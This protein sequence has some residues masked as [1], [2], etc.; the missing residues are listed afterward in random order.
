MINI[1]DE[2]IEFFKKNI[3]SCS[4]R[5]LMNYYNKEII[6]YL[7]NSFI[8][9]MFLNYDNDYPDDVKLNINKCMDSKVVRLTNM[10]KYSDIEIKNNMQAIKYAMY[11]VLNGY[12][13]KMAED[14]NRFRINKL[15][16]ND[17]K[18]ISDIKSMIN[19]CSDRKEKYMV[20]FDTKD[21]YIEYESTNINSLFDTDIKY[22]IV[23]KELYSPLAIKKAFD[24]DIVGEQKLFVY[25]SLISI[26]VLNS[27][28][29]RAYNERY[30]V[31]FNISMLEKSNKTKRLLKIIDN[32]VSKDKIIL[33]ITYSDYCANKDIITSLIQEGFS[34]ACI[35]DEEFVMNRENMIKL[36]IFKY[37]VINSKEFL[38]NGFNKKKNIVII[39]KEDREV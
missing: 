22:N 3:V 21:F 4:K 11:L 36:D 6:D 34:F 31:S 37:I 16:M 13:E 1:I 17:S 39:N 7:A 28:L 9:I 12:N 8:S 33:K 29:N 19:E 26:K 38:Y 5:I 27:V 15:N 25:Y 35:I 30:L 20:S 14:S 18:Y 2:Y 32:D 24:K 23:F 10:K